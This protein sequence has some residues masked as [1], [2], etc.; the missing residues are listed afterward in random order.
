MALALKR[1]KRPPPGIS[2]VSMI[3]V[4]MIM[5]IF[6]MVTSTYLDL[7]MVPAAE[8][9]DDSAPPLVATAAA[10]SMMLRIAP[11]GRAYLRGEPYEPAALEEMLR[12]SLDR[13]PALQVVL[14]PSSTAKMQALVTVMDTAARA[15]AKKVKVLRLEGR[16]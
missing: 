11:D 2:V 10:S 16:E 13:D 6:F 8:R 7:D 3:D 14:L 5:L 15:G 12:L 4:L 1:R 9:A